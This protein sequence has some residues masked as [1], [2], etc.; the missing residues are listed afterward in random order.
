MD[1]G[2]REQTLRPVSL[3]VEMPD[4]AIM[5]DEVWESL[6]NGRVESERT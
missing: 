5:E 6:K 4:D 3:T 1:L 2:T